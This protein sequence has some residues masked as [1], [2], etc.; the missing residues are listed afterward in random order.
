MRKFRA[1]ASR[2]RHWR[3]ASRSCGLVPILHQRDEA[4][5]ARIAV[6]LDPMTTRGHRGRQPAGP[7]RP[8]LIRRPPWA[9]ISG[10]LARPGAQHG[11]RVAG[12]RTEVYGAVRAVSEGLRHRPRR[13]RGLPHPRQP[14][15]RAARGDL[16]PA[17]GRPHRSH[18]EEAA[19]PLPAGPGD[20]VAGHRGMQPALSQL[21][22]LD[23]VADRPR[24]RRQRR[25][26]PRSHTPCWSRRATPTR[27]PCGGCSR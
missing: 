11:V 5:G 9:S 16:R 8:L 14:G 1:I 24:G 27:V 3:S 7:P 23:A 2:L 20:P 25:A 22:E 19:Q 13:A 15:R 21:P 10:G 18:R 6:R 12:R 17:L 4:T 26:A